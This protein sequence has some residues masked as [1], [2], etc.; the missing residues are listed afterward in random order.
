MNIN[1]ILMLEPSIELIFQNLAI[2][3]FYISIFILIFSGINIF[4]RK[5][6]ANFFSA[7]TGFALFSIFLGIYLIFYTIDFFYIQFII[8]YFSILA[9]I[10]FLISASYI[11]I[12]FLEI[13]QYLSS[14]D[15]KT[16]LHF[17]LTI[18]SSIGLIIIIPM[19]FLNIYD[20][21]IS[22]I[23]IGI[24]EI[25]AINYYFSN[26]KGLEITERK[27]P[28]LKFILGIFLTKISILLHYFQA[29]LMISYVFVYCSFNIIGI[30]FMLNAW[31]DLPVL[32]DLN[33]FIKMEQLFVVDQKSS[34]VL[35]DYK[36]KKRDNESNS[37]LA[38]PMFRGITTLLQEVLS[39]KNKVQTIDHGDKKIH[40]S[41]SNLITTVLIV[42]GESKE[43][44]SHLNAFCLLF[45]DLFR[46]I[47]KNFEGNISIFDSAIELIPHAFSN[48][49]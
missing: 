29:F 26:Y 1:V 32:E 41:Y 47:I 12:V 40:F 17:P 21:F 25:I 36:F 20:I 9:N 18:V 27:K 44:Q 38:G 14:K 16:N 30:L 24:L 8:S 5:K 45:E 46:E 28:T 11:L 22:H 31:N 37:D 33:W 42:E 10:I 6:K 34:I 4:K 2:L 19:V 43:F 48:P 7:S 23:F 35:F 3:M 49:I 15:L 39:S 13:D